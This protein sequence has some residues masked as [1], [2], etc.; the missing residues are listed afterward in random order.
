MKREYMTPEAYE[1]LLSDIAGIL[2]RNGLKSTRMSFIASTLKMSKRTLYE[3]FDSKSEMIAEALK[4]LHHNLACEVVE[5]H[6][7][8]ANV[9]EA[10]V[11][12]FLRHRDVMG[13]V[14]IDFFRDLEY[15]FSKAK[16]DTD[17]TTKEFFAYYI[18]LLNK[19]A[20]EGYFRKDVNFYIQCRMMLIQMEA[21]RRM[22]NLFPPEI[23]LLEA[24]DSVNISFLR[25]IAT[26]KG[27]DVLDELLRQI[28][29]ERYGIRKQFELPERK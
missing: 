22:E 5:I 17:T 24:Y 11:R 26:R 27:L 9:M 8:S 20:D 14:H 23:T 10:L 15:H 19:G 3:I 1:N 13:A 12:G 28:S 4:A 18:D 6:K 16:T 21:L 29:R 25:G 7:S 2:I